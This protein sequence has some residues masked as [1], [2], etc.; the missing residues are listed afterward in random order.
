MSLGAVT[1]RVVALCLMPEQD[2]LSSLP[3]LMFYWNVKIL[4]KNFR[5]F[6][7]YDFKYKKAIPDLDVL[8]TCQEK[9]IN[10]IFKVQGGQQTI[11]VFE[12]L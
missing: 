3:L 6:E 2:F 7:K 4:V 8:L 1:W 9:N 5:K 10:E 12:Y 11:A